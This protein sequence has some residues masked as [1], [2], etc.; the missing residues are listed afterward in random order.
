MSNPPRRFRDSCRG[1]RPPKLLV[2][3]VTRFSARD[4]IRKP[5]LPIVRPCEGTTRKRRIMDLRWWMASAALLA[6]A[7]SGEARADWLDGAWDENR[8]EAHGHPA[9][10]MSGD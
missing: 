1:D 7:G 2:S 10:T 4:I 6:A 8:A 5:A 3:A 9:I